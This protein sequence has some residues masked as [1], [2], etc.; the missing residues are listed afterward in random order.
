MIELRDLQPSDRQQL[1][2]WRN[3]P[4]VARWMYTDHAI[5]AEEH[6]RW[7]DGI[8]DDPKGRYWIITLNAEDVGVVNLS[9][10]D[11]S[12]RRC[13][14]GIYLG[15]AEASGTGAGTAALF[16]ALDHAFVGLALNRVSAHAIAD[17]RGAIRTYER[18]G[19]RREAFLRG[20]V[21][22]AG[23]MHD[24]VGLAILRDEWQLV[25]PAIET[26]LRAKGLIH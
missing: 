12:H 6:D 23:S 11:T 10:I 9:N 2:E 15:V 21:C 13:E 4:E 22:K 8:I 7:F 1:L 16:Q 19:L 3:L 18:L 25:R 20:H 24:V 26:R 17:N 5:T 14:F